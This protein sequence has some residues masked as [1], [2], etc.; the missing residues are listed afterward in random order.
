[1]KSEK[2]ILTP[3]DLMRIEVA[4]RLRKEACEENLEFGEA[5]RWHKVHKKILALKKDAEKIIFERLK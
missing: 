1:M 2:I 3:N 5:M 4:L